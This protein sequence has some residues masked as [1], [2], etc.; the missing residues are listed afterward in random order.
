MSSNT[1]VGPDR[2]DLGT[3][4]D[5]LAEREDVLGVRIHNEPERNWRDAWL[6]MAI[7]TEKEVIPS[8][9]HRL[10]AEAGCGITEAH[11]PQLGQTHRAVEIKED[12]SA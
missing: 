3:L 7:E 8:A 4:A 11:P 1:A 12:P 9:V 5:K 6:E 2:S 10:I